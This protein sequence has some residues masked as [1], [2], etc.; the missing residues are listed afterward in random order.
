MM[1]AAFTSATK[2][3]QR[4]ER[5]TAII[6]NDFGGFKTNLQVDSKVGAFKMKSIEILKYFV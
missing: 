1:L 6:P 3:C 5:R 4:Q 2:K